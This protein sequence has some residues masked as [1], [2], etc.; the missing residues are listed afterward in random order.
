MSIWE[1]QDHESKNP[2]FWICWHA[3][4]LFLHGILTYEQF[5]KIYNSQKDVNNDTT[6]F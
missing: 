1:A 6:R 4:M 5:E 3:C 2:S